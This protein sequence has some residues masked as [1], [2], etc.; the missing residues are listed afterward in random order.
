MTWPSP[1]WPRG[2]VSERKR[3]SSANKLRGER[4]KGEKRPLHRDILPRA[5]SVRIVSQGRSSDT[6][7]SREEKKRKKEEKGGKKR[8]IFRDYSRKSHHRSEG[9]GKKNDDKKSQP[10]VLSSRMGGRKEKRGEP[11]KLLLRRND[12]LYLSLTEKRRAEY[13]T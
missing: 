3:Q 12:C 1:W 8:V 2:A 9:L 7:R 6:A 11:C 4:K 13:A 10:C 5:L